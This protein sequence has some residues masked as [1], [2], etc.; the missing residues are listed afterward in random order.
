MERSRRD[1]SGSLSTS[2]SLTEQGGW[3]VSLPKLDIDG[4]LRGYPLNV[5][6]QLEASDKNGKG[7]DIQL[8]TQGLALSHGPNQLSAKGKIDKQILMDV[9]VNFLTLR[10]VFLI[11]RVR[12]KVK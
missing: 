1:I 2:G 8:T 10:K 5:E 12:C 7:E 4:I 9:E 3:Q 11:L 6:G